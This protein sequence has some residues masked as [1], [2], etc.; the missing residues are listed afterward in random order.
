VKYQRNCERNKFETYAD[1]DFVYVEFVYLLFQT[2][3]L[4]PHILIRHLL[5]SFNLLPKIHSTFH[6]IILSIG[7]LHPKHP[8]III[9]FL[10]AFERARPRGLSLVLLVVP[11]V[12]VVFAGQFDLK[13]DTNNGLVKWIWVIEGNRVLKWV[14]EEMGY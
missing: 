12:T 5:I 8:D 7:F 6:I 13:I 14:I 11:G 1:A 4:I 10:V 9:Q 2:I 3:Y